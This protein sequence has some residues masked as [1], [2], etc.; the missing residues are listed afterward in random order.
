MTKL[1]FLMQLH[2]KL[3]KLPQDE[4][5]ERLNFY[6]EMIDDR[7]EEGLSEAIANEIISFLELSREH[8]F[9]PETKTLQD[10]VYPYYAGRKK[11]ELC[12]QLS[13]NLFDALNFE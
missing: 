8:G 10:E 7:M 6:S 3:E 5:E 12:K 9:E 11:A 1:D 4:L 13:R 2:S